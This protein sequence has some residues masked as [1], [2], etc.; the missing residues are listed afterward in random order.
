MI[1]EKLL[2]ILR[3]HLDRH[4][5]SV[6]NETG[7]E[8]DIL[9]SLFSVLL[10]NQVSLSKSIQQKFAE[11]EKSLESKHRDHSDGVAEAIK[12]VKSCDEHQSENIKSIQEDLSN[13][14]SLEGNGIRNELGQ[15]V[16]DGRQQQES[17]TA[18]FNQIIKASQENAA[19]LEK[20]LTYLLYAAG[21]IIV[22][23]TILIVK[24]FMN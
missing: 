5:E 7:D 10:E 3:H 8:H 13:I 2:N 21:L 15:L 6:R 19:T 4:S 20:K 1:D 23:L 16:R 12:Q 24:A 22:L 17:D 18:S 14:I 9:P 11:I